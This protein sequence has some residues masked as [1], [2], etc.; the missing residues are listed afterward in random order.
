MFRQDP[1]CPPSCPGVS[2][3]ARRRH[4]SVCASEWVPAL[5]LVG[6]GSD[7]LSTCI[8]TPAK[9][10]FARTP[11]AHPRALASPRLRG[12]AT[13]LFARLSAGSGAARPRVDVS[14][15]HVCQMRQTWGTRHSGTRHSGSRHPALRQC[16]GA[17]ARVHL[18]ALSA[19]LKP[20]PDTKPARGDSRVSCDRLCGCRERRVPGWTSRLPM[21]AKGGRHGAPGSRIPAPGQPAPGHPGLGHPAPG[22]A[23]PGGL[24][25]G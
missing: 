17:E 8:A 19:R 7:P 20:C 4:R 21:S 6:E 9:R 13:V 16:A 18:G 22:D 1:G 12:D 23:R 24:R 11:A 5:V 14:A 3:P 10:C 25:W 2:S 15:S